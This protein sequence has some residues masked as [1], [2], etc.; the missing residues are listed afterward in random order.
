MYLFSRL[1]P[2]VIFKYLKISNFFHLSSLKLLYLPNELFSLYLIKLKAVFYLY[3]LI[4]K[5]IFVNFH[6][7]KI[8]GNLKLD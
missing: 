5:F 8:E 2:F 7:F 1:N 6:H 4:R 3:D